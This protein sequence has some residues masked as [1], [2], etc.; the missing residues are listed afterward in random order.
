METTSQFDLCP[1]I[2]GAFIS[3]SRFNIS[4]DLQNYLTNIPP[5]FEQT[6]SL[7]TSYLLLVTRQKCTS[8]NENTFRDVDHRDKLV[9]DASSDAPSPKHTHHIKPSVYCLHLTKILGFSF[10]QK[11]DAT[12]VRLHVWM[13]VARCFQRAEQISAWRC[14]LHRLGKD[15]GAICDVT[16]GAGAF[17]MSQRAHFHCED[18]RG[19]T[20]AGLH[21]SVVFRQSDFLAS[22]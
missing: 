10:L 5:C 11:T 3:E 20:Q 4:G 19:K 15:T 21:F 13:E 7:G 2:T 14:R 17:V 18:K 16:E 1:C 12:L 6:N 22:C 8:L 9:A